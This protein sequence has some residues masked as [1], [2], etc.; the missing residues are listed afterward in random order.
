MIVIFG[1]HG[2]VAL[3]L[4]HDLTKR[5][6]EAVGTIRSEGQAADLLE[7]GVTPALV[8]LE[9]SSHDDLVAVVRGADVVAFAAGS[10]G[11]NK[12]RTLAV[13]R[14][15]AI[16][17][18]D[19]AVEAGVPRFLLLSSIGAGD[20]SQYGEEGMGLY[21]AAKGAA[22]KH[23]QDASIEWTIVR[24]GALSDG[25]ATGRIDVGD[26]DRTDGDE[27]PRADVAAVI[28]EVIDKRLRPREVFTVFG[29]DTE[30][31]AAL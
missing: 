9:E 25:E 18:V 8:D 4:G 14:D 22:D 6:H 11:G 31:A 3:Q 29:G 15:A 27:I 16:A 20:E 30:I 7:V 2:Q 10:G 21:L 24:P 28:A 1:G 26:A 13:D 23:V 5:G 17:T 12:E 19:A